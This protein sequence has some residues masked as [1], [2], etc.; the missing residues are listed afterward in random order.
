MD[1]MKSDLRIPFPRYRARSPLTLAYF[2]SYTR[3][4]SHASSIAPSLILTQPS[5]DFLW[6]PHAGRR[7]PRGPILMPRQSTDDPP[8]ATRVPHHQRCTAD[9]CHYRKV[10]N[11]Y[12][13]INQIH[14]LF[15]AIHLSYAYLLYLLLLY[16]CVIT[17]RWVTTTPVICTNQTNK[18]FYLSLQSIP[19]IQAHTL[20]PF[21]SLYI[22]PIHVLPTYIYLFH[23]HLSDSHLSTLSQQTHGHSRLVFLP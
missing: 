18:P 19:N 17:G 12:I 16:M 4:H 6:F 21:G 1:E 8:H 2:F 15:Y 10:I 13:Y 23:L 11:C 7:G 9:V 22:Y 20:S 3:I 5:L 14:T